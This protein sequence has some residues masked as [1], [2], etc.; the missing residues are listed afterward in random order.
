MRTLYAIM[1]SLVAFSA[2]YA[3]E[4]PTPRPNPIEQCVPLKNVVNHLYSQYGEQAIGFGLSSRGVLTIVF[5]SDDSWTV[6]L[7][8]P[9]GCAKLVDGGTGW[10]PPL[11][12]MLP[13]VD[14]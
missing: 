12:A 8:G 10:Q 14:S 2:A 4:T 11:T 5:T 9:D 1:V 6:V 13:G 3:Q 7:M